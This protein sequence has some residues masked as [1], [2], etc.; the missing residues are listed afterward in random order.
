MDPNHY[1]FR[2]AWR[3]PA[4]YPDVLAVLDDPEHWPDWWPQIRSL[5]PPDPPPDNPRDT[6]A[7]AVPSGRAAVRSVLP[8]TLHLTLTQL[9][10]EPGPA[11][12]LLAARLT[13]DLDGTAAWRVTATG[14]A[15]TVVAF[16]EDVTVRHPLMRALALPARPVF[17]ANHAAMMRGFH[18]GLLRRLADPD[19][20]RPDR[21]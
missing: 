18:R 20:P 14:P 8:L 11:T 9:R 17:L 1:R 2:A 6:G 3:L 13:G 4:P 21:I 12:A 19:R 5:A 16:Q 15:R 7:A 10:R